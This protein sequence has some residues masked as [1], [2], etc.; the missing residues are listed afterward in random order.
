MIKLII[1]DIDGTI[2]DAYDAIERSLNFTL[3]KVGYPKVGHLTARRAVGFGDRNFIKNFVKP[4]DV[5]RALDTYRQHHQVSLLKY[6]RLMPG[7]KKVLTTLKKHGYL[8]A[9]ATNRPRAYS[10]VL[11]RHLGLKRYFDIVLCAKNKKE[12]KPSPHLIETVIKKLNV[13]KT[14]AMYVGDMTIDV[15]AGKNAGVKTIAIV[16]GS[17]YRSEL[18]KTKPFKIITQ[19]SELLGICASS[20]QT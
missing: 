6:S 9:V 15:R 17:S 1:F 20:R 19:L 12:I 13:K 16:G 14:E 4:C 7:A 2:V 11:L 5:R 18:K 3:K 8:L 10:A